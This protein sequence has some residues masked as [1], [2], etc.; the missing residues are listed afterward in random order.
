ME[1]TATIA[2]QNDRPLA[3]S[4]VTCAH[5]GAACPDARIRHEDLLFCCT[6]CRAVFQ[7]LHA[8]GLG[9]FYALEKQP[10]VRVAE[11]PS[12]DRFAFLDAG[13]L[14]EQLAD[15]ADER[16]TRVTLRVPTIHC[17][18]CVW[19]LENLFRIDPAI[20]A[21][22]VNFPRK[23]LTLSFDHTRLPFSRLVQRLAS[24]GYE[25]ELNLGSLRERERRAAPADRG[26]W[27]RIGVAGFAFGNIMLLSF[28]SYLGLQEGEWFRPFFG[29]LS[30]GLSVPVLL[31]SA[32]DY[33][34]A[35]ALG[36]RRRL[37]TIEFPIAIGLAALFGQSVFEVATRAGEGYFDSFSG[38]VFFLLCGRWFQRKSFD[39][40]SFERDFRSYFPLSVSRVE[41]GVACSV[42]LT[43]L[44]VGDR[45]RIRNGELLPADA[46]LVEGL[47]RLDYSFVTGEAE[48]VARAPG[49]VVYAGGRQL[50]A[51]IEVETIKET[52]RS[53]LAS[54]WDHEAFRKTRDASLYNMTNRAGRWFTVGVLLFALSAAAWWLWRAPADAPRIFVSILIVA[55]P[56]ALALSAPFAFG[57]AVRLL[58]R[59]R[60]FLKNTDTLEALAR[61][62]LVVLDKTG[63][64]TRAG[65]E[66]TF[67]GAPLSADEADA[68]RAVA[69]QSTH[70]LSRAIAGR[71]TVVA[72]PES[73][74]EVEGSGL[75]GRARGHSVLLGNREWLAQH[76]IAD[77][78]ELPA[79]AAGVAL[80]GRFRGY[81]TAAP[82]LRTDI[83]ELAGA[84]RAHADV[85]LL[86]GDRDTE[87]DRFARWLG[88]GADLRFDQSPVDKLNAVRAY[89]AGG[90]RVAMV[91]DGLND[92]GALRQADVG[93]AVTEE[94]SSFSPASDIILEADH[95]ARLPALLLFARRSVRVV[96]A[97]FALSL[98]Y[99]ATGLTFAA[100]GLLSPLVSAILMPLSSFTVI[101]F[102]LLATRLAAARSGWDAPAAGGR[103]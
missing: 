93:I 29:W 71:S 61:V 94:A 23:E 13:S 51:A 84:L 9:R 42:P 47:A 21:S 64:L 28:P 24:L 40:L 79:G 41:E 2:P 5:C 32:S 97:S 45:L 14:R 87:R 44:R 62:D 16:V 60:I 63:T 96:Y 36:I 31:F 15:Y 66:A 55:C 67:A 72:M 8:S 37:L 39:W 3:A 92:A 4:R 57:A 91:G 68:V 53:Y 49:D 99:N 65:A 77:V 83:A 78:P 22:R 56:C 100:N 26:L 6:G 73:F 74:D 80:D 48:P 25:P 7:I 70:P 58:A 98:V 102:A 50:G 88:P 18:A 75:R 33:W 85:A 101:S 59:H 89:Q 82:I 10:G 46:R 20:G 11:A 12:A 103:R 95:V 76:A 43:D 54:L 1:R 38:L 52:S 86:S 30:F 27:L 69:S 35:A 19:L 81:Y 17:L 90:R 34:R